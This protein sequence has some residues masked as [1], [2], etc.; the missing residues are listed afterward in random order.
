MAQFIEDHADFLE[1]HVEAWTVTT[2]GSLVPGVTRHYIRILPIA[3]SETS[4]DEDPNSGMMTIANTPPG[5]Q[6]QFPAKEIVDAGFLELVRYGIRSAG[7]PLME[8][9]LKVIDAVLKVQTPWGPCWRRYNHD[10]YGPQADGKPYRGWGVGRAWPLLTGE[11][12]H[13]ELAAGR[14]TGAL[15]AAI[16][17]FST[18][19][20][21]LPEQIWDE[22]D[23]PEAFMYFGKPCGAAMPLMWAHAEYIKLLR[24]VRDGQ[25]FDWIMPVAARY[26]GSKGRKDLEVWKSSRRVRQVAAGTILRVVLRG[27]FRLRWSADGG[28]N[29]EELASSETGLDL[30]FVDIPTPQQSGAVQFTFAE[31]QDEEFAGKTFE[32]KIN[33]ASNETVQEVV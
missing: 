16:E 6:F 10:G 4:P 13:H 17:N 25:V 2:Q 12:A 26:L 32:V 27:A 18:D 28:K 8:A 15:I 21:M 7:D 29:Y 31:S 11:R 3:A 1:S 30:R 14:N 20:G 22:R 9:S 23:M 19:T 33:K 24:S 5:Q